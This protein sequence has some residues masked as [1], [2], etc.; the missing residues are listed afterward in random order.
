MMNL[1]R[2]I[3]K[4]HLIYLKKKQ[5]HSRANA[6]QAHPN[7][8]VSVSQSPTFSETWASM[9]CEWTRET[10]KILSGG[11]YSTHGTGQQVGVIEEM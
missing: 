8:N 10:F 1:E 4:I 7:S 3:F 5:V 6:E 2:S 9:G 11:P